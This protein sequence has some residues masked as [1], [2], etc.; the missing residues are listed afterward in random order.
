VHNGLLA[1]PTGVLDRAYLL[2]QFPV[3]PTF[4]RDSDGVMLAG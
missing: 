4:S 2:H 1:A 3:G